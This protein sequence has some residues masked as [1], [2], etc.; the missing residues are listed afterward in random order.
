MADKETVSDWGICLSRHLQ[1]LATLF[2]ECF[3]LDCMA[4]LKCNH[5]YGRLPKWLKAMVAYLKASPQEKTILTIYGPQGKKRRRTP[6]NY[7][8]APKAKQLIVLPNPKQLVSS[9]CESLKGPSWQ[10]KH[11]QGTWHTWKRRVPRGM[12]KWKVKTPIYWWGHGEI[13]G[14]PCESHERHPD[15]RKV[16]LSL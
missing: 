7:P 5:F 12:K 11:P 6:W 8:E 14:A 3:P 15:G 9:P 2:P 10:L 4:E 1:V 13:H 16:L